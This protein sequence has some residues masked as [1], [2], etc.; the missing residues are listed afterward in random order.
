MRACSSQP[1]P[2]HIAVMGQENTWYKLKAL[3]K[4]DKMLC[5]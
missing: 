3:D 4:L 2:N 1:A 5:T